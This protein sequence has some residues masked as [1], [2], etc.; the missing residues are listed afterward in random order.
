MIRQR[1]MTL[2]EILIVVVIVG[3][4]AAIAYPSYRNQ[5]LSSRRADAQ[6]ALMSLA[7]AMER[8]HSQN[9]TYEGAADDG[10]NTGAPAIF[11]DEAPLDGKRKYYNL[12]ITA[13]SVDDYTLQ[14]QP[15][16]DQAGDGLLEITADGTRGWDRD[17]NGS[18]AASEQCWAREC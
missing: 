2:I 5:V 4:L 17:A 16:N 14:A 6:Q 3:I 10:E 11:P 1:G 7:S 15:K 18:I 8:H 12:R 13:A 9:L